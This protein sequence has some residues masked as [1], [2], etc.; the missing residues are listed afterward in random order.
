MCRCS[1]LRVGRRASAPRTAS[2]EARPGARVLA[3]QGDRDELALELQELRRGVAGKPARGAHRDHPLRG[4]E[5]VGQPLAVPGAR[6]GPEPGGQGPHH[7]GAG[8]GRGLAREALRAGQLRHQTLQPPDVQLRRRRATEDLPELARA[9][10]ERLGPRLP[11]VDQV[12]GQA[13]VGL[14]PAGAQRRHLGR[15]AAVGALAGQRRLDLDPAAAEGAHHLAR[16]ALEVGHAPA[17]RAPLHAEPVRETVAELGLVEVAGG[18]LVA[19]QGPAVEG[20]GAPVGAAAEVGH[21]DVGVQ[22]RIERPRDPVAEGGGHQALGRDLL[23]S[24]V[25]AP[26]QGGLPFQIVQGGGHRVLVGRDHQVLQARV[27]Q[28]V[29]ERHRLRRAE[30]QVVARHALAAGRRAGECLAVGTAAG[31][32]GAQV[33]GRHLA[34]EA[35]GGGALAEPHPRR[36]AGAQVVVLDALGHRLQVVLGAGRGELADGEQEGGPPGRCAAR[37]GAAPT[38]LRVLGGE[39]CPPALLGRNSCEGASLGRP[40]PGADVCAYVDDAAGRRTAHCSD[41][42]LRAAAVPG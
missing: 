2:G 38:S 19:I 5:G 26:K 15:P 24:G 33:I 6:P 23:A 7:L 39:S 20:A 35:E 31:Q 8:E 36:L 42:S 28:R 1:A 40:H 32:D 34:A 21:Q 41:C 18:G 12:M 30:G 4:Q 13:P 11:L 25:S 16:H 27:A 22:R 17:H 14:G 10:A 37:G 3:G 9:E 29:Q